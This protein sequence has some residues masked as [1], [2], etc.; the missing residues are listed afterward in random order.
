MKLDYLFFLDSEFKFDIIAVKDTCFIYYIINIIFRLMYSKF[1]KTPVMSPHLLSLVVA[2]FETPKETTTIL[3][4]TTSIKNIYVLVNRSQNI[5]TLK[6]YGQVLL[7][8]LDNWVGIGYEK[9]GID[10][11]DFVVLPFDYAGAEP[12]WGLVSFQ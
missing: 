11:L 4:S 10:K 5:G 1:E 3:E 12:S 6:A 7:T 9:L 8:A 2:R